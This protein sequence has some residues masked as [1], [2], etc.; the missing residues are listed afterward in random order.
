MIPT[1]P[2]KVPTMGNRFTRALGRGLVRLSGW[3]M[4]GEVPN[5]ARCVVA[6]APHTSNWDFFIA[7]PFLL[8]LGIKASW[9]MKK[10]AF[11]WPGK[12]LLL[13]MGGVPIDREAPQ[14]LVGQVVS[15]FNEKEA[16]W[17][18]LT[19]EGTRDKVKQW[20]TGF[21][22]MAKQAD[23]PIALAGWDY[24]NKV[25]R[26]AGTFEPSGDDQADLEH[27]QAI[28][29]RQFSAKYPDLA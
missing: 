26:F 27:I 29:N 7:I 3:R 9:L 25:V 14:G 11:Y 13:K 15:W 8:A 22:Q 1:L 10:E 6:L 4:E 19:P 5:Q 24:Q 12:G 20:K 18:V 2:S 28:F 17:V 21:L 23:V 16:V